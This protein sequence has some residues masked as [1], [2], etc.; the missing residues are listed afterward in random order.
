[1]VVLAVVTLAAAGLTALLVP[2]RRVTTDHVAPTPRVQA[3]AVP[4]KGN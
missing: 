4:M 3:C 1:M 2:S